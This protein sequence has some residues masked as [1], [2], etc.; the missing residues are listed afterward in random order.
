MLKFEILKSEIENK[1]VT[2]DLIIFQYNDTT[3][4]P[5][6]YTRRISQ[7]RSIPVEEIDD[8]EHLVSKVVDVFNTSSLDVSLRV[9]QC[10]ELSSLS[11]DFK[12]EKNLII[13][14]KKISKE[15]E[16]D[17]SD[18]ICVFPP[19]EHWHIQDY[20]YSCAE[21]IPTKELDWLISIC[22]EDIYRL[23]NEVDKLSLF[24]STER[25]YIFDDMK[26]EGAFKDLSSFNVFNI[27]NAVTSKDIPNLVLALREIK[28]FDAE[29]LGVV[30]LL[31]QGFRKLIRVLLATNPTPETTGLNSKVIYAIRN[32]KKVYSA[33]QLIDA[34]QFL[35]SIDRML[36]E[37]KID[38]TWLIDYVICKVLSL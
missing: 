35:N 10:P 1:T 21:G 37:G 9:Y 13:I 30:T 29:P 7:V 15:V 5:H 17:F 31:Y 25:K 3:F 12:Q 6:D 4:L 32:S 2:D 11:I 28:S 27:T 19:L 16:K 36:K 23:S 22:G 14:T 34:F 20:V 26:F 18:Y 24:E 8:I 38:T 33:N